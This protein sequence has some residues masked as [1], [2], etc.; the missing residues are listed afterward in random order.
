M[1]DPIRE[2]SWDSMRSWH[3]RKSEQP[4][5]VTGDGWDTHPMLLAVPN[6]IVDLES[7]SLRSGCPEDAITRVAPVAYDPGA[8]CPRWAQFMREI[9]AGHP[10]LA[11]YMQRVI[12]YSLTGLTTEQALWILF[13][14]GANGKS[15]LIETLMHYVL[16]PELSWTMPFPSASWSDSMSEYQK[17]ALAGRR[18]VAS[19][20]K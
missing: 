15:T 1:G 16:G 20:P 6:G 17:A 9:F 10:E 11:E 13:G 8:A 7:G 14:S 2:P 18:F 12:G 19:S 3:S 4:L 5:A